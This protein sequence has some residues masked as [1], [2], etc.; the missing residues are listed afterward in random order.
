MSVKIYVAFISVVLVV[1]IPYVSTEAFSVF[2]KP[3]T[4][5]SE[6]IAFE[7][8]LTTEKNLKEMIESV[9]KQALPMIIRYSYEIQLSTECMS[10]LMK[11]I[12]A[13]RDMKQWALEL[14]ESN[15]IPG[16]GN[17]RGNPSAY[18]SYHQCLNVM[19]PKTGQGV[20]ETGHYCVITVRPP[21]PPR[22]K[23]IVIFESV[24]HHVNA[25][26]QTQFMNQLRDWLFIFYDTPFKLGVCV[27]S[28]CSKQDISQVTQLI[29]QQAGIYADVES[30]EVKEQFK[31][32]SGQLAICINILVILLVNVLATA[33][34]EIDLLTK[35]LEA[36]PEK[37]SYPKRMIRCF[38]FRRNVSLFLETRP[39]KENSLDCMYGMRYLSATWV[40]LGHSYL[41]LDRSLIREAISM[42]DT[43]EDFFF[44]P[45][46]NS[47]LSVDSFILIGSTLMAYFLVK[48]YDAT[49]SFP[50]FIVIVHRI[51][52]L[53]PCL[54]FATCIMVLLPLLGSGPQYKTTT[55]DFANMCR[56]KW[57]TNLL[58]IG[59]FIPM[60]E[61]CL[62]HSWYLSMDFQ[63]FLV[64]LVYLFVL[65][66]YKNKGQWFLLGMI[67]TSVISSG[68]VTYIFK[69][70]PILIFTILDIRYL[71]TYANYLYCTPNY[72]LGVYAVGLFLG[73]HLA[74]NPKIKLSMWTATIGWI[75]AIPA[76]LA[77][78]YGPWPWHK[79]EPYTMV[80]AIIFSSSGRTVWAVCL[81]WVIMAC[82]AGKGGIIYTI[83]SWP[84]FQPL[85][86]LTYVIYL[87]HIIVMYHSTHSKIGLVEPTHLVVVYHFFG[88]LVTS[89]IFA[90]FIR[91]LF[92]APLIQLMKLILKRLMP[93][94]NRSLLAG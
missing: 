80:E 52:R 82:Y 74:R 84:G 63:C 13:V 83:L 23:R 89:H 59:N 79:G 33:I 4:E 7:K 10:S 50:P 87:I 36:S 43:I 38:S 28:S 11:T 62:P 69:Y 24:F 2:P 58:F 61:M 64:A 75:V 65:F 77:V 88:V 91:L 42:K 44:E 49:G 40:V 54:I 45:I 60:N 37:L 39:A 25:T 20:P 8:L 51:L 21:L 31:M 9:I 56:D 26:F 72:H 76:S 12:V 1:S 3:I 19:I 85:V 47:T 67:L 57:W 90:V 17:L 94:E 5:K 34:D 53:F 30:C 15:G 18:G 55:E 41:L 71:V 35:D 46:A 32:D 81:A 66:R 68:I 70:P 93:L 92:E 27:P 14:I 22:P 16:G 73:T 48:F 29:S 86:R 6:E 78:V